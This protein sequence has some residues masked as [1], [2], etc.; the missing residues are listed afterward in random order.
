MLLFF[1]CLLVIFSV[2]SLAY[3]TY[4]I[5]VA[6]RYFV[7]ENKFDIFVIYINCFYILF[8]CYYLVHK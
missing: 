1:V 8:I 7:L 4:I 5:Y 6:N 3:T 2:L